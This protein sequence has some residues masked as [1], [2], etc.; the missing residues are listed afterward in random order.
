L[1]DGVLTD[2]SLNYEAQVPFDGSRRMGSSKKMAVQ[3]SNKQL[4]N[5]YV[6]YEQPS[7]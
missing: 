5:S 1:A 3:T 2:R 6:T 4:I 7:V